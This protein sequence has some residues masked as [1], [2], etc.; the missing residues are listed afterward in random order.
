MEPRERS[1][2]VSVRPP[3]YMIRALCIA[4]FV[5]CD[6]A[7]S[8]W[9]SSPPGTVA[10][11]IST[12]PSV[13]KSGHSVMLDVNLTN[14]SHHTIPVSTAIDRSSLFI[15]GQLVKIRVHDDK[16]D[17]APETN[18]LRALE[19]K[20]ADGLPITEVVTGHLDPGKDSGTAI[21]IALN[22][23]YDLSRPGKYK[24]QIE[25]VDSVSKAVIKSNAIKIRIIP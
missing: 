14:T 11:R 3:T 16:G 2:C 13:F 6:L 19:G 25:C 15:A 22:K 21:K 4:L 7:C 1:D 18:Y 23:F 8:V 17:L 24:I 5:M 12:A 9:C 20:E 10:I